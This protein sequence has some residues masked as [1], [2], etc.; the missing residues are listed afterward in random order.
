MCVHPQNCAAQLTNHLIFKRIAFCVDNQQH[1][2]GKQK[3]S[4]PEVIF[5]RSFECQK[6][7]LDK[8]L[9]RGDKWAQTVRGR[10]ESVNDLH[11]ADAVYHKQCSVN[12]RTKKG[13]P[14]IFTSDKSHRLTKKGRPADEEQTSAFLKVAQFLEGND[15]EQ[16]T[17]TDL[18]HKMQQVLQEGGSEK[19]PYGEQHLR[20]KL[21]N[22]F[23]EAII[24]T[25]VK[26]K[27]N[28]VT[29]RSTAEKILMDFSKRR[30]KNDE[31]EKLCIIRTAAL[32]LLADIK[33]MD[34]SKQDYPSS[35]DISNL[36]RNLQF[37]PPSMTLLLS[38][39][40]RDKKDCKL[41]IA[42]IG[43]TLVQATR[44]TVL[45][46]PL[47]LGLGVEIHHLT[48]SKYLVD[49]LNKLGFSSS[50][51]EVKRYEQSAAMTQGISIQGLTPTSCVQFV[52]DNV[53]H[54][55]QTVDGTGT[56][57]GMGMIAAVT[58][59]VRTSRSIK[60]DSTVTA[61]QVKSVGRIPVK[62]FSSSTSQLNLHYGL[63]KT[64][65]STVN[66]FLDLLWKL[67][68]PLRSPRPGWSGAMQAVCDGHYPGQSCFTFLPM[69]DMDPTDMSCV[70]TTLH[71]L[72]AL[73]SQ[74]HV[75]PVM[76]S[77]MW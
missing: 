26:G 48:G 57:H 62:M 20:R 73:A 24:V 17:L 10:I 30:E 1:N 9:E 18:R 16:I 33:A 65:H 61:E 58:P 55:I 39:L 32:L 60:R 35:S 50:Y 23:G 63:L 3:N 27:A 75:T 2:Y 31:K 74:N 37:L 76:L 28:V 42:S 15:D 34:S 47:Q 8:C 68:W 21:E 46:S 12:F 69:I 43:Q 41:K 6:S 38:T 72:S 22:H 52:A 56:F 4:D 14:H 36:D 51:A 5:I 59:A 67:S 29:F 25:C 54:N 49:H 70:F 44:P 40:L 66:P 64:N 11:A 45:I 53:D 19:E 13:I 77:G 71:F 7:F